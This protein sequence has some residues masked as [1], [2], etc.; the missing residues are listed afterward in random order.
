MSV[1][2][3]IEIIGSSKKS[4]E[5]ATNNAVKV[6]AKTV[7]GLKGVELVKQTA[8]IEKGKIIEYRAVVKIAFEYERA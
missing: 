7:R 3:I 2:K 8:V 6:A 5:D 4:W 1:A